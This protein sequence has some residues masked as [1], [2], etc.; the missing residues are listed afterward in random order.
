MDPDIARM[1]GLL[2]V[3]GIFAGL[4]VV[5][6]GT[7]RWMLNTTRRKTADELPPVSDDRFSRLEDAVESIAL[8]VERISE[9]QR[10]TA[11]LLSDRLPDREPERLPAHGR[12]QP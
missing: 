1:L 8:E 12:D 3:G 10:F 4:I 2:L 7:V 5:G 9:A 6:G 11:K